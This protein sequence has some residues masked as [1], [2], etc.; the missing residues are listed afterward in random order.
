VSN[1]VVD[2]LAAGIVGAVAMTVVEKLEQR[3]TGRPSSYVP[4]LTLG[5]LVGIPDEVA[6][7]STTMNLGMHFGQATLLGVVRAMMADGGLRGLR[8]SAAFTGLRLVNDQTLEN[9]TGAGA[10]PS[11]WPRDELAIDVMHKAVY[12]LATGLVADSLAARRGPGAGATH[13]RQRPGRRSDV[14]P[15]KR[16]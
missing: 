15:P 4:A 13:A 9:Y 16:G 5:R 11:T 6:E 8:T 7:R 12:A 10:P 1:V 3:F 2:G 14:G